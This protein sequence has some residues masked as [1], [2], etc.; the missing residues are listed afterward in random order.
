[1]LNGAAGNGYVHKHAAELKALFRSYFPEC[2]MDLSGTPDHATLMA[3]RA[4]REGYDAVVAVGGDGCTH[5]VAQGLAGKPGALP[6]GIVPVGT[7]GD[8]RRS[9][10]FEHRLDAYLQAI[11]AGRTRAVDTLHV[12]HTD[13]HGA[14]AHC[15]VVNV[16]SIG[17]GGWV[18]DYV[19]TA[20]RALGP[21]AAYYM[22]SVRGLVSTPLLQ[23]RVTVDGT[24]HEV[25]T[26]MLALCKGSYFGAGMHIAPHAELGSG[27]VELVALTQ[28]TRLG[29]L[30]NSQAIYSGKHMSRAG[31]WT[32]RGREIHVQVAPT[33]VADAKLDLDGEPSGAG[34]L[35]VRVEA[36]SLRVF[37]V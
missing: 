19:R 31:T 27:D 7:G 3:S 21:G 24:V 17:M 37:V 10:G 14:A 28:R 5:Y 2:D 16:A 30:T 22:A 1:M 23:L 32:A 26:R 11:K 29:F 18:D 8:Y 13:A 20:P 6:L 25:E 4:E 33:Q 34:N 12:E 15:H 36:G 9:L 35:A